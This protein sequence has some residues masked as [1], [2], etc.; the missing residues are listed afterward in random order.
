MLRQEF[1]FS[2]VIAVQNLH[3]V[4]ILEKGVWALPAAEGDGRGNCPEPCH[5]GDTCHP[6]N[7]DFHYDTWRNL[8]AIGTC[9]N[10]DP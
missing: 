1:G 2:L 6:R 3:Q 8:T 5:E 9:G 4:L 10:A 7:E